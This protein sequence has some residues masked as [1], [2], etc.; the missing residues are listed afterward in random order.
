MCEERHERANTRSWSAGRTLGGKQGRV[1]SERRKHG[2]GVSLV[3]ERRQRIVATR[4]GSGIISTGSQSSLCS[5]V[6]VYGVGC[7][8]LLHRASNSMSLTLNVL[9]D[10][11]HHF[12][13]LSTHHFRL[14]LSVNASAHLYTGTLVKS[15]CWPLDS[16]YLGQEI[17]RKLVEVGGEELGKQGSPQS[18]GV[19]H[20]PSE[21][22]R[23]HHHRKSSS[24]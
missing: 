9:I 20:R 5:W 6:R 16:G 7:R 18:A 1:V 19:L 14:S 23:Q 22:R 4:L 24:A 3:D 15:R 12:H 13:A 11:D 2:E 8:S 17:G 21:I 10:L